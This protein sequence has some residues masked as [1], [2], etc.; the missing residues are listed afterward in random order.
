MRLIRAA[1]RNLTFKKSTLRFRLFIA[2]R[3][4]FSRKSTNVINIISGIST[5]GVTVGTLAL[6]ILLSAFNGLESWVVQLYNSFDPDIRIQHVSDKF[7][8][9]SKS[10]LASFY[11]VNGVE[12]VIP[13]LEDNCLLMYKD[14]QYVCTIKGVGDIFIKI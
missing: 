11:A 12:H 8:K 6:V 4:L 3:Y 14:A 9:E 13:V 2:K 7:F 10:D 1:K 5:L